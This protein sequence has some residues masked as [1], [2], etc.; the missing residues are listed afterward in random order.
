LEDWEV[1]CPLFHGLHYLGI[2]PETVP[3]AVPYLHLPTPDPWPP[4]LWDG[5][6]PRIGVVWASGRRFDRRGVWRS[7]RQRS[8]G[9][10]ALEPLLAH[11]SATFYGLQVGPDAQD[12]PSLRNLAPYIQ[13]FVDTAWAIAHLDLVISVDTAVAHVVGA[14]G[15]PVWILLPFAAD[16]RWGRDRPDTPW[17][18]TARLFRQPNRGDWAGA[19]AQ[20]VTALSTL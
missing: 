12:H 10:A 16:W 18:P 11:P 3:A 2:T 19:I 5:D 17:Y 1:H 13:S 15:K 8:C 20:V 6:R 14:L 4:H 7:Y 9:L